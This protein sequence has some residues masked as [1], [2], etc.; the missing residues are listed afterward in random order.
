[1]VLKKKIIFTKK[2]FDNISNKDIKII[3]LNNWYFLNFKKNI[4][5]FSYE[6]IKHYS[7][8]SEEQHFHHLHSPQYRKEPTNHHLAMR[9]AE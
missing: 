4:K 2:D 7:I 3:F 6:I 5:N 8:S 9:L 1:M